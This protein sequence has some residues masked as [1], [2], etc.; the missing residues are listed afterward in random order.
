MS[1]A[2]ITHAA[3]ITQANGEATTDF[4]AAP[5]TQA[6]HVTIVGGGMVGLSLALL[7]NR[8]NPQWCIRI[9]EAMALPQQTSSQQASSQPTFPQQASLQRQSKQTGRSSSTSFDARSTALSESTRE[10]FAGVGI[11]EHLSA[12]VAPI[13]QVHVSDR[14][15]MGTTRLHA[16]EQQLPALGYVVENAHLGRVLMAAVRQSGAIQWVSPATVAR[17]KPQR[18]GMSIDLRIGEDDKTVATA[19]ELLVVAD[20]ANSSMCQLLGIDTTTQDY[21]QQAIVANVGLQ[22]PH[23]GVAYERFTDTGPMALLP[24]PDVASPDVDVKEQHRSALVWTL[25]P[26]QAE[27]MMGEDDEAF[28]DALNSRFG[29]RLGRFQRVGSRHA[30]PVKLVKA[31][32]QVRSHLVVVGNA[33][34]SLHPVAGQGFNLALRDVAVLADTLASHQSEDEPC[35]SSDNALGQL[36]LLQQYLKRQQADQEQTIAL[37][38]L[39]PKIFGN[40]IPPVALVRNLGLASMDAIPLLRQQFAR[41]GMGLETPGTVF[42]AMGAHA[43]SEGVT[44]GK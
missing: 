38:D 8:V 17:V 42:S 33:A 1:A 34:H 37:S 6:A 9:V 28:I 44:N 10:I 24:L 2:Q 32:E 14:G 19:T 41:L 15:H 21:Q 11:W 26:E 27:A 39:L 13:E 5:V 16:E 4:S 18:S 35:A 23:G 30:Y 43:D 3:Q 12:L 36:P 25:P 22:Q 40:P 29:F 31:Q 20:G 7:L